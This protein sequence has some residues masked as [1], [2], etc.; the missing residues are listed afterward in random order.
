MFGLLEFIKENQI[1]GWLYLLVIS[2]LSSTATFIFLENQREK[3][4]QQQKENN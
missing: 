2:F 3:R 1:M 4:R